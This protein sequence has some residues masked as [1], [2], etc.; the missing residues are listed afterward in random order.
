LARGHGGAAVRPGARFLEVVGKYRE[1]REQ[2]V[3][4]GGGREGLLAR[5]VRKTVQGT[6]VENI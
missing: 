1:L 3:L 5:V 6:V 4:I 2:G